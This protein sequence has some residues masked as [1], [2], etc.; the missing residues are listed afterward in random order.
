MGIGDLPS[1]GLAD[2]CVSIR[3]SFNR[4]WLALQLLRNAVIG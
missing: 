3:E 2:G 4:V 1:L